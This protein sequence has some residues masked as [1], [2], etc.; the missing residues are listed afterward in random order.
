M[1]TKWNGLLLLLALVF[2]TVAC[3]GPVGVTGPAGDQGPQGAPGDDGAVGAIGP[4]GARGGAGA[5]GMQGERGVAGQQ[6][7]TGIEGPQG[8]TGLTGLT[9]MDGADGVAGPAG[10]AA[11]NGAGAGYDYAGVVAHVKRSAVCVSVQRAQGWYKCASGVYLDTKGTVLTANH[12]VDGVL[13]IRV[14]DADGRTLDY[15]KLR[16]IPGIEGSLLA[17][18]M[19]Q[20]IPRTQAARIA[21]ASRQGERV[22]VVGYPQNTAQENVMFVTAGIIATTTQDKFYPRKVHILDAIGGTG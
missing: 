17:P 12:V 21:S 5:R 8:L 13:S 9:G 22:A 1:I 6:G 19:G 14:T 4:A 3:A 7:H 15:E 10:L 18:Q 16:D 2:A 20:S 11:S